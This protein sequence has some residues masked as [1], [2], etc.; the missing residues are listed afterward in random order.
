MAVPDSF[1]VLF[2]R[3]LGAC[4]LRRRLIVSCFYT[5]QSSVRKVRNGEGRDIPPLLV[6]GRLELFV[7]VNLQISSER[8]QLPL[9]ASFY[10]LLLRLFAHS[11][12]KPR[13]AN[14]EVN[15]PIGKETSSST[16][17]F[18]NSFARCRAVIRPYATEE[19]ADSSESPS[20][21]VLSRIRLDCFALDRER[22]HIVYS[23][24]TFPR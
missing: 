15:E 20:S 11:A 8:L 13:K 22:T 2:E 21:S 7:F 5:S 4:F 6:S 3:D 16:A 17:S 14:V 10:S 18:P 12:S 24:F 23:A 1:V 19:V 9:I